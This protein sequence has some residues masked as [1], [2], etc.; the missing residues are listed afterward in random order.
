MGSVQ[1]VVD[2]PVFDDLP[3]MP[4]AAEQMLVEALVPQASI[5]ASTKTVLHGFAGAM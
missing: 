3:G 5:E 2:P 4:I 1:I